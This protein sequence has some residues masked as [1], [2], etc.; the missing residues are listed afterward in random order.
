MCI[1]AVL[2]GFDVGGLCASAVPKHSN[3]A[4]VIESRVAVFVIGRRQGF[5]RRPSAGGGVRSQQVVDGSLIL[6]VHPAGLEPA[7]F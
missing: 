7:T 6:L 5:K 3:V 1:D 4:N 2:I